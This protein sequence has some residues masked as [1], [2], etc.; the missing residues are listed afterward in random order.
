MIINRTPYRI[1]L[2]GGGTDHKFYYKKNGGLL[3]SATFNQY[4]YTLIT[5]RKIDTKILV[6]TTSAAFSKNV[7][8]VKHPIIKA[9]LNYFKIKNKI[10]I[11]TFA[12]VPTSSGLGSSS[13]LVVSLIK[14]ISKLKKIKLSNKRISEIAF[15]IER[16]KLGLV[17]GLQ[18]QIIASIG[19]ILKIRIK[20]NGKFSTNKLKVGK[21]NLNKLEKH[22]ILV[23]TEEIRNSSNVIKKQS[24]NLKNSLKI[25]DE[26]KKLVI[27]TEKAIKKGD[28]FSLGRIFHQ[29]WGLKKKLS[30]NIS[31]SFLDKIY[32]KLMQNRHFIG[33]KIIGAGGGGFFLMVTDNKNNSEIFLKKNKLKFIDL[34]FTSQGTENI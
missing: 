1:P 4:V 27:P 20:K 33:G 17:G 34:K 18:D 8:K 28:Y 6:Q 30:S 14:S 12:T 9:V 13:S 5:E 7:N 21:K 23:F 29:H 22:L 24:R 32:I 26:L 3:L 10:Q 25:Y 16:K 31:S 15:N 2:A 11:G 19:G